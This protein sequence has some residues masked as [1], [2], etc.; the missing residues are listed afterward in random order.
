MEYKN[1]KEI[2]RDYGIDTLQEFAASGLLVEEGRQMLSDFEKEMTKET[3]LETAKRVI[4]EFVSDVWCG[5]FNSRNTLGDRMT[6]VYDLDGLTV[7]ICYREMYFEVFGLT[8]S[9]FEELEKF[10]NELV[11]G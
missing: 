3:K 7:D 9:E 11:Y 10:Y 8:D 5:I 2:L 4:D 1:I 6:T